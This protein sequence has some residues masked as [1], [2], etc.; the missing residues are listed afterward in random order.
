LMR[1]END[2]ISSL[3][4]RLSVFEKLI[5]AN[6]SIFLANHLLT[7][8]AKLKSDYFLH[9]FELPK[10]SDILLSQPWSLITYAFVHYS[11]MHL[12][13][14]MLMLYFVGR[15]YVGLFGAKNFLPV[16]LLGAL[17]GGFFF[18][19][20]YNLFPVFMEIDSSLVGASAGISAVLIYL[21]TYL[22]RTEV[23]FFFFRIQL[24]YIGLAFVVLDLVQLPASNP[25]GH[26]AHLGGAA[27]GFFLAKSVN[28][29][30]VDF[31]FLTSLKNLFK[32]KSKLRSVYKNKNTFGNPNSK[33]LTKTEKQK[34]ID[35]ILDKISESG[36]DTLTKD[37]KDFLFQSGKE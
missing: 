2:K 18:W 19:M 29:K 33:G 35:H 7:F 34:K 8:L 31:S 30:V 10:S 32:P 16:Y 17:V 14:N 5:I 36:Y 11:F 12:F 1:V 27:L 25:G 20:G 15:F 6:V 21:C 37:E 26:L 28:K 23:S 13:W 22:P 9:Y 24:M 3:L 4:H